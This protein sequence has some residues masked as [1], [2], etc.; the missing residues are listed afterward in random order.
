MLF[1]SH[2]G[3]AIIKKLSAAISVVPSHTPESFCTGP[4]YTS[5]SKWT[6]SNSDL[7]S[8]LFCKRK[9]VQS[10]WLFIM[11]E[12][13]HN[14]LTAVGACAGTVQFL[15][16]YGPPVDGFKN[17]TQTLFVSKCLKAG[18]KI[19]WLYTTVA[20]NHGVCSAKNKLRSRKGNKKSLR[21]V[22]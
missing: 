4:S 1:V 11:F 16:T 18:W 9:N 5:T 6:V 12:Y 10:D 13:A 14:K 21:P 19:P 7:V 2:T 8:K 20:V 15:G 22:H 3:T 17:W